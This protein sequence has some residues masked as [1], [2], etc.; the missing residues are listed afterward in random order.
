MKARKKKI[1]YRAYK[2]WGKHLTP[3]FIQY[4]SRMSKEPISFDAHTKT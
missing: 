2:F 4:V 3:E 1:V